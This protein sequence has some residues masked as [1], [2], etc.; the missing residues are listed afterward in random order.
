MPKCPHC[1]DMIDTLV[2]FEEAEHVITIDKD[3]FF[4]HIAY[5]DLGMMRDY[6]NCP[7][8]GE[9]VVGTWSDALEFLRGEVDG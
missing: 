9:E 2:A 5:D 1:G 4:K 6:Y 7:L 3:G 8:C